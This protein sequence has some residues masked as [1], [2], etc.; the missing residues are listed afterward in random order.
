MMKNNPFVS[1]IIVSFNGLNLLKE[2][3]ASVYKQSYPQDKYEIIVVD[4][5]STDGSVNYI[6]TNYPSVIVIQNS[7][8]GGFARPN[9]KAAAI[10]KGEYLALLNNDMY[11]K[12]NWLEELVASQ[13]RTGAACVGGAILNRDGSKIDFF[14]GTI[15][16]IGNGYF[17]GDSYSPRRA[18]L[19]TILD[20]YHHEKD[21]FYASGSAMLIDKAVFLSIGGFDEDIY[22][23]HEDDDLCWRLW[24]LGHRVVTS[25]FAITF[26][27]HGTTSRRFAKYQIRFYHQRNPLMMLYKNYEGKN[28]CK[29]LCG[30]LM[31]RLLKMI[32]S[33][34]ADIVLDNEHSLKFLTMKE[35]IWRTM[36]KGRIFFRMIRKLDDLL[37]LLAA[38]ISFLKKLPS[39][40]EK[41][42]ALQIARQRSDAEIMQ[43]F[44]LPQ[45]R[46]THYKLLDQYL[47]EFLNADT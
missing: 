44:H 27:R 28:V 16:C 17:L 10:A 32:E 41:R 31:W 42:K 30:A 35:K 46:F 19:S 6:K 4:N 22:I 1:I 7:E 18:K 11:A 26:H 38:V 9:N 3:L 21:V 29:Y 14:D 37:I 5:N 36:G 43:M 39:M 33:L 25:P 13:Q 2:C 8:N 12:E 34:H 23:Y 40:R 24:L 45:S 47:E 20:N 15:D